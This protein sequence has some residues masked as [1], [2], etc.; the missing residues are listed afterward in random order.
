[1]VMGSGMELH[2]YFDL[3]LGK[4]DNSL[5]SFPGGSYI[6]HSLVLVISLEEIG[7]L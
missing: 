1:M 5:L 6:T 7:R 2:S 4:D 3:F